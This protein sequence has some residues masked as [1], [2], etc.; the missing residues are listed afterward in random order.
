M[1]TYTYRALLEP[2]AKS[3]IIAT[4]PDIPEAITQ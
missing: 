2:G 1:R 4:F 3:G